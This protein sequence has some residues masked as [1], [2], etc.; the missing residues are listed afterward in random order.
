MSIEKTAA[1]QMEE[2]INEFLH[3]GIVTEGNDALYVAGKQLFRA[4]W[5]LGNVESLLYSALRYCPEQFIDNAVASLQ[6]SLDNV[7]DVTKCYK[8]ELDKFEEL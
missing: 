3:Y 8:L 1:V 5:V 4:T 7:K 2:I 6:I